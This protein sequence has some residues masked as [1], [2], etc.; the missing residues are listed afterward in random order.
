M[1]I[2]TN[3]RNEVTFEITRHCGVIEENPKTGWRRELNLVAWNGAAEPKFDVRE[4]SPDHAK[5]NRGITLTYPQAAKL[6]ELLAAA[7]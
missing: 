3:G 1:A 2:N 5:M 7:I 4:W 6:A